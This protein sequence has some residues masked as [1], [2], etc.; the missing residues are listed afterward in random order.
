MQ[1]R[2]EEDA[3]NRKPRHTLNVETQVITYVFLAL[4]LALVAYFIYFMA[5]KSEDFINNPANPRVKGFEKLVV[6]GEIKAS[7][8]TVL[9]K[10]VTSNGEEVR[11]YPKGREYA[12][13]V[14][15]KSNG[16][17]GIEEIGRASV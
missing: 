8:G 17:S 12:H 16:M 6:R 13:V 14:G 4:F 5:F 15:Y 1:R 3:E 11:E 10:T 9:A 2:T 7:D